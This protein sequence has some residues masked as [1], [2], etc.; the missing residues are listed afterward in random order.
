MRCYLF[1][2]LLLLVFLFLLKHTYNYKVNHLLIIRLEVFF[3]NLCLSIL[4]LVCP[5][6]I[7]ISKFCYLKLPIQLYV[8]C[9][10]LQP[11]GTF[12][13]LFSASCCY[14]SIPACSSLLPFYGGN[15]IIFLP[16]MHI[17]LIFLPVI[18]YCGRWSFSLQDNDTI[19]YLQCFGFLSFYSFLIE[20]CLHLELV[21]SYEH[22]VFP[23]AVRPCRWLNLLR[24]QLFGM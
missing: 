7:F 22:T 24:S 12:S 5:P 3:F 23:P 10:S 9:I 21:S 20:L 18:Y 4:F 14:L 19:F 13:H 15:A 16:R 1:L 6:P 2:K 8:V 11:P 17:V